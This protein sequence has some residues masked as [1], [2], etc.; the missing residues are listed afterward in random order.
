M[1]NSEFLF[2]V[3]AHHLLVDFPNTLVSARHMTN[4]NATHLVTF[5]QFGFAKNNKTVALFP[6]A[7]TRKQFGSDRK[8]QLH[9]VV[10][11]RRPRLWRA[12]YCS[13]MYSL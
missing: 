5:L 13:A 4:D 3:S 2:R 10:A 6:P 11:A 12:R 9:I 1:Q 7:C 8:V